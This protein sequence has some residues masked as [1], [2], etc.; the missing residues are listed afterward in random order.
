MCIHIILCSIHLGEYLV[1][2]NCSI[3]VTTA[4]LSTNDHPIANISS[5]IKKTILQDNICH[6]LS[7]N[8]SYF[9]SEE[10]RFSK[11]G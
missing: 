7:A 1:W 9:L 10:N 4:L 2:L 5:T 11:R 3:F 8:Q 6:D